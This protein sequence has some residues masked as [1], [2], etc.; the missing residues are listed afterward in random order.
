MCDV[1]LGT[2]VITIVGVNDRAPEFAA[3]WSQENPE[4][5]VSLNEEVPIG[6][7]VGNYEATD[8]DSASVA[9]YEINPESEYFEINNAS[10]TMSKLKMIFFVAFDLNYQHWINYCPSI[11]GTVKTKQRIDFE[12]TPELNFRVVAWDSGQPPLSATALVSVHVVNINDEDPVFSKV[13]H[14]NAKITNR[15]NSFYSL[16]KIPSKCQGKFSSW[17]ICCPGVGNGQRFWTIWQNQ[18]FIGWFVI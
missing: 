12:K 4:V 14:Q 11:I 15:C 16:D 13:R 18:L 7:V 10:G 1:S 8:P 3:P 5:D 9:K 6:T 2:L 17:N